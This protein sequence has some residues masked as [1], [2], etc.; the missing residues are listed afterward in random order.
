MFIDE[1]LATKTQRAGQANHDNLNS[2]Y[3]LHGDLKPS[4][5]RF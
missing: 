5:T 4:L 2:K 1:I 3:K